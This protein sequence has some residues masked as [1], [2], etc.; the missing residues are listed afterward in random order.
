MGGTRIMNKDYEIS[1]KNNKANDINLVLMDRIPVSQNKEIKVED[2][3]TGDAEVTKDK[4]LLTW[5][6]NL[7]TKETAKKQI[8]YKVKYPRGRKINL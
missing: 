6:L 5:K 4:G 1:V 3:K 7:K 8:S 2:V